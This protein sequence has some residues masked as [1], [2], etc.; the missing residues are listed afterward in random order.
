M[1]YTAIAGSVFL[2]LATPALAQSSKTPPQMDQPQASSAAQPKVHSA[3]KTGAKDATS[4]HKSKPAP[5]PSNEVRP[6]GDGGPDI[7]GS[8]SGPG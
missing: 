2:V 1:K 6:G 7:G 3:H 4:K 5:K 8:P